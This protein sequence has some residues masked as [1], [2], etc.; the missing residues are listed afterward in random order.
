MKKTKAL[1]ITGLVALVA[2]I[3]LWR[4]A[5]PRAGAPGPDKFA[6]PQK[7]VLP[8]NGRTGAPPKGAAET[9]QKGGTSS[10]ANLPALT[11]VSAGSG[12]TTPHSTERQSLDTMTKTLAAFARPGRSVQDLVS[13]L[14]RAQTEPRLIENRNEVTGGMMI[15]RTGHLFPGTRYFHAQFFESEKK[16]YF[17][18]HMSFEFKPGPSSMPQAVESVRQSFQIQGKPTIANADFMQWNLGQGYVVWI[19]KMGVE[20]LSNNPFNA[21][22]Q[23]DIGSIRV[24]VE[25]NPHEGHEHDHKHGG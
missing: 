10:P 9:L 7:D 2:A 8:Q 11:T 16:G 17:P 15:V 24:A 3:A 21:Y 23:A 13:F 20:D 18:Q 6:S 4:S 14:Q 1:F 25:L 22:T 12:A 5:D 19:K